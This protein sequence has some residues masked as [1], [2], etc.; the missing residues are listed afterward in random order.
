MDPQPQPTQPQPA[1]AP[2]PII[3]Q[4]QIMENPGQTLGIVG[5]VLNFV[6]VSIGGIILGVMSRNRSKAA[7]MSTALGTI[8]LVWGI[9]TTAITIIIAALFITAIIIGASSG[10]MTPPSVDVTPT[11]PI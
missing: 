7:N 4:V 6:G 3:Q 5:L 2:A 9:V 11:S 8:S 1:Q 10:G